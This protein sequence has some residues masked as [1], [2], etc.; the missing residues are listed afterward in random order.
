M[1][2]PAALSPDS[3]VL[4]FDVGSRRIG[5]AIGSA[6]SVGARALAVVEVRGD[7]PDWA[8]LDRLQREWRPHGLIVGDPLTL[9]GDDQPNRK[10]AQAFARQLRQR[11]QVPVLLVDERSSSVEAA[12]RFAVDRAEGRKRRRDAAN[13]DAVAAAVIIERWLSAPGDATP[14]S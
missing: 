4:G 9:D 1:P 5:V 3:T 11:Y 8:A 6:F 12:R 14:V 2:D 7:G 13:L 10:R